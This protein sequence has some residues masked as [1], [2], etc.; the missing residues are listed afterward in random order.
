[1]PSLLG[2][3]RKPRKISRPLRDEV[4]ITMGARIKERMRAVDMSAAQIAVAIDVPASTVKTWAAGD[5]L[6]SG[7]RL[8]K[9]AHALKMN[10]STL[11]LGTAYD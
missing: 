5:A 9:L 3:K 11:L 6:P 1:M 10:P 8:Q 2:Q 4:L 7:D